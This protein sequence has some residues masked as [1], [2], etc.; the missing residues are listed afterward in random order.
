MNQHPR[1]RG[2]APQAGASANSATP[3]LQAKKANGSRQTRLEIQNTKKQRSPSQADSESD[4]DQFCIFTSFHD[5]FHTIRTHE[6][7]HTKK[8]RTQC[9]VQTRS[10]CKKH[11]IRHPNDRNCLT[12]SKKS[13][14]SQSE[15]SAYPRPAVRSIA[16][17]FGATDH[18]G[19]DFRLKRSCQ[20]NRLNNQHV[21]DRR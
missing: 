9:L 16:W 11:L 19:K 20:M 8:A 14:I 4:C 2:P 6:T 1:K 17:S 13:T 21:I 3:A 7:I 10:R 18:P 5:A 12:F 15:N